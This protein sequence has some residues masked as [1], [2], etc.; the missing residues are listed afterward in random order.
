MDVQKQIDYW[1]TGSEEDFAAA[2]SLLALDSN[3]ARRDLS[4]AE[5]ML[6]WLRTQLRS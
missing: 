4:T 2:Q 1:R 3:T 5:E 6:K